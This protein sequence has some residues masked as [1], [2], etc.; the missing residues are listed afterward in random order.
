MRQRRNN[1]YNTPL[2]PTQ[3][4]VETAKGTMVTASTER[5][6][7]DECRKQH[8]KILHLRIK[9]L[10]KSRTEN[11]EIWGSFKKRVIYQQV[12]MTILYSDIQ[13]TV[14]IRRSGR[15]VRRPVFLCDITF[16]H[17]YLKLIKIYSRRICD[18]SWT[19]RKF[20]DCYICNTISHLW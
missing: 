3:C 1:K 12:N 2:E 17:K 9:C 20:R 7:K 14:V 4:I 13:T 19:F 18:F 6:T 16:K 8:Q 15:S 5:R 10:C 11:L